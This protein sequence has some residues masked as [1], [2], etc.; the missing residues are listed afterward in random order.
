MPNNLNYWKDFADLSL[1]FVL[2]IATI[3]LAIFT[4]RL[5]IYTYRL[6][7]EARQSRKAQV[8][9]YIS[10]YLDQAETDPTLLFIIIQNLGQGTAYNLTFDIHK[11]ISK[12]GTQ[13]VKLEKEDCSRRNEILSPE[14]FEETLSC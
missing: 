11:D 14:I 9:P 4:Y 1:T 12:Y 5:A 8:Q 10:L 7:D 13:A 2:T 3:F 6:V